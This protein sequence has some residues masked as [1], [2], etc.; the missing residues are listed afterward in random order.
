VLEYIEDVIKMLE[1][2]ER[3]ID[4]K[5]NRNI[6]LQSVLKMLSTQTKHSGALGE[7]MNF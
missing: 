3:V 1:Y 2:N 4:G 5:Y 6:E 7:K